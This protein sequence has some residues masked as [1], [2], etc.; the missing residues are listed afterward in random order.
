MVMLLIAR[1]NCVQTSR[2]CA[3]IAARMN[4]RIE[5]SEGKQFPLTLSKA[6]A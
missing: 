6:G 2:L 5:I 4:R 1:Y 3:K